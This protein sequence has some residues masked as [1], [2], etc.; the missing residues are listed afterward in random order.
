MDIIEILFLLV[1]G[2]CFSS[3]F[4]LRER[5]NMKLGEQ[6]NKEIGRI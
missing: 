6:E 1:V 3:F 5:E 2:V 4:F